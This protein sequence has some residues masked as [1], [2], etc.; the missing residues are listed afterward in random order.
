MI[1]YFQF[2]TLSI[3]PIT[4]QVWGLLVALGIFV[5]AWAAARFAKERGQDEKLVWDL[6]VWLIIAAFVGGRLVHVIY[7]PAAYLQDPIELV[8]LW[9]GGFSVM[10]GFLG[11]ALVG[12]WY[13][14]RKKKNVLE[15]ADTLLFGLPLGLFV[16]RIGCL[17]IHDHPGVFSDFFLAVR[18]P[19]GARL[20]HGLLLSLNGLVLFLVFLWMRKRSVGLGMYTAVFL[21]WYGVVRFGL[22]FFRATDGVIVDTRYLGLT[23]AQYFAI[24]MVLLGVLVW[25]RKNCRK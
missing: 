20:D 21:L 13:L 3:G 2:T 17:L 4:I 12:V 10:G 16:G 9:H 8:R 18:F 22:D 5:G 14:K 11:A 25:K 6:A 19:E 24:V 7:E 23:P 15:Y 1:P